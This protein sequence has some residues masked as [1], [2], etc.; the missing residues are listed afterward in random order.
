MRFEWT[1]IGLLSAL[2]LSLTVTAVGQSKQNSE[3]TLRGQASGASD[4]QNPVPANAKPAPD[5][6]IGADDVLAVNV[7]KEPEFSQPVPVRSDGNI[8][9][10][11][12]GEIKAAG[13]TPVQLER[14]ITAKL[15]AYFKDPQVNVMVVQ[16][17][18]RK[19][20]ILGRVKKPGAY[21][22]AA[23]KTVLD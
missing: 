10:P 14:D 11:L 18:S 7:W 4:V 3:S 17:N 9:L 23:T 21:S 16:M 1:R 13:K 5:Y 22:L 8:S 15:N 19:F 20:N 6:S 2:A 12:I